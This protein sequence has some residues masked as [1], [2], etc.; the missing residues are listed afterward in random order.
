MGAFMKLTSVLKSFLILTGILAGLLI[1]PLPAQAQSNCTA[2]GDSGFHSGPVPDS[3]L[4]T[5]VN[6]SISD[7]NYPV[8]INHPRF[9]DFIDNAIITCIDNPKL[10][11][12]IIGDLDQL[13]RVEGQVI[14]DEGTLSLDN[15]ANSALGTETIEDN[16]EDFTPNFLRSS[17]NWHDNNAGLPYAMCAEQGITNFDDC[18]ELLGLCL[19]SADGT[20]RENYFAT[21]NQTLRLS[22]PKQIHR[23]IKGRCLQIQGSALGFLE[24]ASPKE[25]ATLIDEGTLN[26][27]LCGDVP[28]SF[29]DFFALS[30]TDPELYFKFMALL[31][32]SSSLER[33]FLVVAS[34]P[35]LSSCTNPF[36]RFFLNLLQPPKLQVI[37]FFIPGLLG[38]VTEA[39]QEFIRTNPLDVGQ[40]ALADIE[41]IT[42]LPL[43]GTVPPVVIPDIVSFDFLQQYPNYKPVIDKINQSKKLCQ[44]SQPLPHQFMGGIA[45]SLAE[46]EATINF[47]FQLPNFNLADNLGL[48]NETLVTHSAWFV[49]PKY[50]AQ[51]EELGGHNDSAPAKGFIPL[52]KQNFDAEIHIP[53]PLAQSGPSDT[54]TASYT[55]NQDCSPN[56]D[57]DPNCVPTPTTSCAPATICPEKIVGITYADPDLAGSTIL[58]AMPVQSNLEI[59]KNYFLPIDDPERF[60]HCSWWDNLLAADPIQTSFLGGV[61]SA[62]G[63]NNTDCPSS[64]ITGADTFGGVCSGSPATYNPGVCSYDSRL[65]FNHG[66]GTLVPGVCEDAVGKP[67]TFLWGLDW[68]HTAEYATCFNQAATRIVRIFEWDHNTP[69]ATIIA[70]AQTIAAAFSGPNDYIVFGNELNNLSAEYNCAGT[71]PS[72]GADYARQYQLF[73]SNCPGCKVAAAPVDPLNADFDAARFLDGARAAYQAS[74]FIAANVYQGSG[75]A[76]EPQRCTTDSHNWLRQYTGTEGKPVI[77]TEFGLAPGLD[78]DLNEVKNF[79]TTN[80]P[81]DALA[82][83]PLVRNVCAAGGQWLRFNCRDFINDQGQAINQQ[84]K[85]GTGGGVAPGRGVII[86]SGSVREYL[87]QLAQDSCIDPAYLFATINVESSRILSLSDAQFQQISQPGW[88]QAASCSPVSYQNTSVECRNYYCYDTCAN[89][90]CASLCQDSSGLKSYARSGQCSAGKT[91]RTRQ[92]VPGMNTNPAETTVMGAGQLEELTF[93]PSPQ[94]RDPQDPVL[95]QRCEANVNLTAA[96]RKIKASKQTSSCNGWDDQEVINIAKSYWGGD[97]PAYENTILALF[98]EYQLLL[99]P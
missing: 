80:L 21:S 91:P 31:Q 94:N 84:A 27:D 92:P 26:A 9:K 7:D 2:P 77:I 10:V 18:R 29:D 78:T 23:A 79:I 38:A 20:C 90:S 96:A 22:T 24:E 34:N 47:T 51:L 44:S 40:A 63:A 28:E 14:N 85:G 32:P 55:D 66:Y 75:C 99:S 58:G 4:D 97:N 49:L 68:T 69:D 52:A 15:V 42:Y 74:D 76:Y 11:S 62:I 17:N 6:C 43:E 41:Y 72:C 81:G 3:V 89:A 8:N 83:T 71:L 19:P 59:A 50:Y 57:Y 73:K 82:I 65:G 87:L 35:D 86:P 30:T 13:Y 93:E 16:L 12:S 5:N 48:L 60:P 54:E 70:G 46:D 1:S 64:L 45:P 39:K 25:H 88:W 61:A 56:P 53:I 67:V 98:K 33:G 95:M 36:C 37:E